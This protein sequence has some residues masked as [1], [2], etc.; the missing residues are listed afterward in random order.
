MENLY[1]DHKF[2]RGVTYAN[3]CV[4]NRLRSTSQ[5][6]FEYVLNLY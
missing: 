4:D 6:C 3:L 1:L 2:L 5:K